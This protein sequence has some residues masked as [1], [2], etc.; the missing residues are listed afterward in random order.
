VLRSFGSKERIAPRLDELAERALV[1]REHF[2]QGPS[3]RLSFPSLFTSLYDSQIERRLLGRFPF[4]IAETNLL[5]A[6]V[7]RDAGYRTLAVLPHPYFGVSNWAGLT[8]GF[9]TI[10]ERAANLVMAGTLHTAE[11][12]TNRALELI[13]SGEARPVFAWVHYFDAHPPHQTPSG[14]PAASEQAAYHA[15]VSHVD[16]HIGRLIDHIQARDPRALVIVTGDH[17]LAFDTPRHERHHYA[18]DLSTA[19]LHVPLIVA[20]SFVPPGERQQPTS[21]LDLAPTLAQLARV[22]VPLPFL[23]RSLVPA[24]RGGDLPEPALTFSQF[25]VAEDQLLGLDP[26]RLAGARDSGYNLVLDRRTGVTQAWH[27]RT[28]AE[29]RQDLWGDAR[30]MPKLRA[31]KATLDAFVYTTHR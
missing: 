9:S 6:E 4:P 30:H 23:G 18:F 10:D 24:L 16:Q 13:D 17:S 8:Q 19:V 3:T 2:A 21:A 29:E 27:Y 12:V 31:L 22:G 15:E 20:S 5:A 14:A 1:F 7:L 25:F 11:Q 28:D 26:L